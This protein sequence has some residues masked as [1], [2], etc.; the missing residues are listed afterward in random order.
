[1]RRGISGRWPL[2]VAMLFAVSAP[3]AAVAEGAQG[4]AP[5]PKA[6]EA[7]R[8][9]ASEDAYQQQVGFLR[10]EALREP[11]TAPLLRPYVTHKNPELRASSLRA[12]AAIEG[13]ASVPLLLEK[14][15]TEKHPRVR[16]AA[17]LGLEPFAQSGPDIL[18]AFIRALRD[19]NT[20]VRMTAVD[21]VSR[22]ND[23]R[24]REAIALRQKR[25][26]RRDVRRVL[27]QARKR[28]GS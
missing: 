16:R 1:M 17:I 11:A 26:R 15:K 2:G 3:Q 9:V 21:V 23:P 27:K 8:L 5:S 10:L 14:L 13:A 6:Q 20:Q 19:R 28:M 24:A 22:I 12:L 25:E 4:S 7:L 18:P